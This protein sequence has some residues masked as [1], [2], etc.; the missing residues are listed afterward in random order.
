SDDLARDQYRDGLRA[1]RERQ[2]QHHDKVAAEAEALKRKK[3]EEKLEKLRAELASRS[4][5]ENALL[6]HKINQ[7]KKAREEKKKD[8]VEESAA[9]FLLRTLRS[10]PIVIVSKSFCPYSRKAKAAFATY[11]L[12][13]DEV[14]YLELDELGEKRETAVQAEMKRL[15]E[16]ERVPVVFVSGDCIGGADDVITHQREGI[17]D[18]LVKDAIEMWRREKK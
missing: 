10:A 6:D 8:D 13:R 2:Q 1:A 11:R 16:R 17:L 9:D 5:V 7:A 14:V 3:E 12:P 4:V 18:V 15:Y